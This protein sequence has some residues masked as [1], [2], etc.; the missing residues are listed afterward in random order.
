MMRVDRRVTQDKIVVP[1]T[2]NREAF[3]RQLAILV[4]ATGLI[5]D[6]K[7]QFHVMLARNLRVNCCAIS[8]LTPASV[9]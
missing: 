2:T 8:I 3:A 9:K 1:G 4:A 5:C 7:Y 6:F